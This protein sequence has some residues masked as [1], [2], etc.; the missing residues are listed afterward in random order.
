M[1]VVAIIGVLAAIALPAYSGYATRARISEV[2]VA[3][4]P[5]RTAVTEAYASGKALPE[6]NAWGCE[7]T[8]PSRYVAKVE[9][10]AVGNI[11]V[12]TSQDASLPSDARGR[13]VQLS[14]LFTDESEPTTGSTPGGGSGNQGNGN[15]KG[16][17]KRSAN[18]ANSGTSASTST[19]AASSGPV[20]G[21]LCESAGPDPL[22]PRYLPSTCR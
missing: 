16:L 19:P 11:T 18:Q 17:V 14:P 22:N 12:T 7:T 4:S 13:T 3:A 21:F 20:E 1:I 2:L 10:D 9:T 8:T 15:A 5:C 6:P